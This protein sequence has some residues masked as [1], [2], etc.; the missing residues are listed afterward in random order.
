MPLRLL[1]LPEQPPSS[2]PFLTYPIPF[3]AFEEIVLSPYA[4]NWF[5]PLVRDL[6]HRYECPIP[7]RQSSMV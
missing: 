3:D 7:V 1:N 2:P 4:P 5:L 6:L